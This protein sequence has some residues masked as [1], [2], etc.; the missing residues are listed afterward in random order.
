GIAQRGA[1]ALWLSSGE[2]GSIEDVTAL[3]EGRAPGVALGWQHGNGF[4]PLGGGFGVSRS[5][6]NA[7]GLGA[8]I[9]ATDEVLLTTEGAVAALAAGSFPALAPRTLTALLLALTPVEGSSLDLGGGESA[10]AIDLSGAF[11]GDLSGLP[12]VLPIQFGRVSWGGDMLAEGIGWGTI[13]EQS[14]EPFA[15]RLSRTEI[16]APAGIHVELTGLT[17]EERLSDDVRWDFVEDYDF[18]ALPV[19][20][21]VD[22]SARFGRGFASGHVYRTPGTYEIVA[23]M[24]SRAGQ[25][26]QASATVTVVDQ[27]PLFAGAATLCYAP[28]GDFDGAPDGAVLSTDYQDVV[29]AMRADDAPK[30]ILFRAGKVISVPTSSNV[31]GQKMVSRFGEGADPILEL[32]PDFDGQSHIFRLQAAR[33]C[34]FTRL[35][36]RGLYDVVNPAPPEEHP[37]LSV[38]VTGFA[39]IGS[40]SSFNTIVDV[41]ISGLAMGI[42][43]TPRMVIANCTIFDWYDYGLFGGCLDTAV[44]GCNVAQNLDA[45]RNDNRKSR[46]DGVTRN[47]ADHG[48]MRATQHINSAVQQCF[49]RSTAGWSTGPGGSSDQPALRVNT[50]TSATDTDHGGSVAGNHLQGGNV[51]LVVATTGNAMSIRGRG[52]VVEGN[53]L[54]GTART[55]NFMNFSLTPSAVR[56]NLCTLPDV[57]PE[58]TSGNITVLAL[59]SNPP[60]TSE[61]LAGP[62]RLTENTVLV[63]QGREDREFITVRQP[64]GVTFSRVREENNVF[65]APNMPVPVIA[66]D[67]MPLDNFAPAPGSALLGAATGAV[68][69]RDMR[70]ALRGAPAALGALEPFA[71]RLIDFG[72]GGGAATLGSAGALSQ[73]GTLTFAMRASRLGGGERT[74]FEAGAD[75]RLALASPSDRLILKLA[76]DDGS[77]LVDR[78]LSGAAVAGDFV[79]I[80]LAVD[81]AG[82]LTGGRTVSLWVDGVEV[83]ASTA[84]ARPLLADPAGLTLMGGTAAAELR[85]W[86]WADTAVALDPALWWDA[87]FDAD[88][89]VRNLEPAGR[90]GSALPAIFAGGASH[91]LAYGRNRGTGPRLTA[92][93]G[94]ATVI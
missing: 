40:S 4:R 23:T 27:E 57:T 6:A 1:D 71:G 10:G 34:T 54:E 8:G 70:S 87:F 29:D 46:N 36:I 80:L 37:E 86:I 20:A 88:G 41:A 67:P 93:G 24:R 11:K 49:M 69:V 85:E 9:S 56:N 39:R 66:P 2:T 31:F 38:Q 62:M 33:E 28:D 94:P 47:S 73:S 26:R 3:A 60:T 53:Y 65:Y 5:V 59:G 78:T 19:E 16:F 14:V 48:P 52:L 35:A 82:G 90:V 12:D 44:M 74:L 50:S 15:I 92:I 25:V 22:R 58:F 13:P 91:D 77:L 64:G 61:N 68:P 84:A 63:F 43:F 17:E 30:R 51:V 7:S 45:F 18:D 21:R 83:E 72:S 42:A 79:S 76:Y 32:A 75:H 55:T 81:L 89:A